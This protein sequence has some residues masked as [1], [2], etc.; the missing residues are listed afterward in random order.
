MSRFFSN[1]IRHKNALRVA[2]L[3]AALVVTLA[4]PSLVSAGPTP[5]GP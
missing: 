4:A 2:A 5:F 3:L 1:V